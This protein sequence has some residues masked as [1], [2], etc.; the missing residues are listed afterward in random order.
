M[1]KSIT[2]PANPGML[3]SEYTETL[4]DWILSRSD[5]LHRMELTAFRLDLLPD[6]LHKYLIAGIINKRFHDN[7]K[8]MLESPDYENWL[9]ALLLIQ[10][11]IKDHGRK[12]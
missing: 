6:L 8:P 11:Q 9:P 7:I 4:I 1:S 5:D 3:P 12:A 2:L 10:K